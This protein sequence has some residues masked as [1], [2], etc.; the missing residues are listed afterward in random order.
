[1]DCFA[2]SPVYCN[3]KFGGGNPSN[4][5]RAS[6]YQTRVSTLTSA[7][8]GTRRLAVAP[9]LREGSGL[10]FAGRVSAAAMPSVV[11]KLIPPPYS[12]P[13]AAPKPEAFRRK[14]PKSPPS[15]VAMPEK[16]AAPP[17]RVKILTTPPMA[18]LPYNVLCG[19]RRTSILSML[20]TSRSERIA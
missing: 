1:M 19:P 14:L 7:V 4:I 12:M 6:T 3:V 8:T 10:T 16:G 9:R 13:A 11:V 15:A 17:R 5:V 20:F 2:Y 18:S